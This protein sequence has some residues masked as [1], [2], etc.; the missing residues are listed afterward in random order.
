M[1]MLTRVMKYNRLPF[2]IN[3]MNI[4]LFLNK[5]KKKA[6]DI[7]LRKG[8]RDTGQRFAPKKTQTNKNKHREKKQLFKAQGTEPF[9]LKLKTLKSWNRSRLAFI[10][11]KQVW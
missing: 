3:K 11:M 1:S 2:I 10:L 7:P 4:F 5:K 6:T 9:K 8:T